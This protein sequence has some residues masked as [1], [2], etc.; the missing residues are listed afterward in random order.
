MIT[1]L[2]GS[3][4]LSK[5]KY[6]GDL[7]K[8]GGN[9]EPLYIKEKERLPKQA[10]LN[11]GTLFGP[12]QCWVIENLAQEL[13]EELVLAWEQSYQQ[14]VLV[15]DSIDKRTKLLKFLLE[16]SSVVEFNPPNINEA[17]KWIASHVKNLG[18]TIDS[19]ASEELV[20]R[21]CGDVYEELPIGIC[22]NEI[23]KLLSYVGTKKHITLKDVESL[24]SG[25]DNIDIFSLTDAL[26]KKDKRSAISLLQRYY[27]NEADFKSA[28]IK[29]VALWNEQ[30]RTSLMV[31]DWIAQ[32]VAESEIL[33]KTGWKSGRLYMVKKNANQ[34]DQ[35]LLLSIINKLVNL[36]IELK[37]STMPADVVV[38][39]IIASL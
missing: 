26:A 21:L 5:T 35:K 38:D 17:S 23:L 31:K 22:H 18:G 4:F 29:L 30:I 24:T 14:I 20:R 2:L 28:T 34:F 1:L 32:G 15:Q 9:M 25:Q 27:N 36:D 11:S 39:L 3:E 10:D 6:L 16:H 37:T 7:L 19:K 12:K 13:N 33:A 8:N